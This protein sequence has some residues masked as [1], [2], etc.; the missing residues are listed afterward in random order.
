LRTWIE[1]YGVPLALYVD[2][3]NLYKGR[4]GRIHA[5]HQD[6]LVKK[7]RRKQMA[8]HEAANVY[9]R[10]EDLPEH[11]RRLARA[12]A[13]PEDYLTGVLG[14]QRNWTRFSGWRAS[15]S[16]ATTGWC[17]TTTAGSNSKG[18][19]VLKQASEWCAKRKWVPPA[20]HPW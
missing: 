11:N 10:R 17:A 20:N 2:W 6:R 9:L 8:S 19:P 16:S 12:A 5:T 1:K 4:I 7:L 15:A 13:K 14:A 18:S 3:K